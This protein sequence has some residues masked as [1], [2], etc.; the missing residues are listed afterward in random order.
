MRLWKGSTVTG[1]DYET[2]EG[3]DF[4][5]KGLRIYGREWLGQGGIIEG[6]KIR[7]EGL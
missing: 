3:K 2:M 6:K 7:R 5:R 4:L 1:K